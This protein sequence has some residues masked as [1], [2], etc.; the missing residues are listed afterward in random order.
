MLHQFEILA[1]N[2]QVHQFSI[3]LKHSDEDQHVEHNCFQEHSTFMINRAQGARLIAELPHELFPHNEPPLLA[4]D[5]P[6]KP[7]QC[8]SDPWQLPSQLNTWELCQLGP[9]RAKRDL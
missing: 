3:W 4:A 5:D 1:A 8:H 7:S 6:T 2:F 9:P